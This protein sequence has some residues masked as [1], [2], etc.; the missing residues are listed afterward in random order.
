MFDTALKDMHKVIV[1]KSL[2]ND[3]EGLHELIYNKATDECTN[4]QNAFE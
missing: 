1:G 3:L 2:Q 4:G